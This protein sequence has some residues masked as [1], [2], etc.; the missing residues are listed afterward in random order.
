MND[1]MTQ[2]I[3]EDL[4]SMFSQEWL[5]KIADETGLIKRERIIDPT[6]MFWALV[7]GFG[8]RLQRSLASLKR[9]YENKSGQSIGDSSWY[10]RFTPE[11]VEFLHQCVIHGIQE[12]AKNSEVKLGKKLQNFEDI[13]IQFPFLTLLVKKR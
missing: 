10:Y 13:L 6:I 5:R 1:E 2:K 4:N 11:L 3:L 12:L 8:V 9:V 7:L